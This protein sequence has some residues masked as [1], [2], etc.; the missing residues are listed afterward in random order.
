MYRSEWLFMY[1]SEWLFMHRSEWLVK[2]TCG[3]VAVACVQCYA[4][5]LVLV[6]I[7]THDAGIRL[8]SI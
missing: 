6:V 2:P 7:L 8:G 5:Q 4:I 3:T 1:R